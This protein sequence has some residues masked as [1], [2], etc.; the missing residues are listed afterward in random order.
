M[1]GGA[2]VHNARVDLKGG[3]GLNKSDFLALMLQNEHAKQ[4]KGA[5]KA[6]NNIETRKKYK[7]YQTV[8]TTEKD[9]RATC[10]IEGCRNIKYWSSPYCQKH[11][12]RI[13]RTGTPHTDKEA[14]VYR[15]DHPRCSFEG[16]KK[17]SRCK[18]LCS[19]HYTRLFRHGSPDIVLPVGTKEKGRPCV[20][21][22]CPN[23]HHSIG[24]C[25]AHY[26]K[27]KKYGDPLYSERVII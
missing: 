20:V 15:K 7:R 19:T 13:A 8:T 9:T 4:L 16:C 6:L 18:T 11:K 25:N 26:K 14:R 24:Y 21:E 3:R 1:G 22:G 23:K 10:C 27:L 17:P 12:T 2:G 5:K